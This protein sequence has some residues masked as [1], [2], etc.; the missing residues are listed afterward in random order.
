[1]K[2]TTIRKKKK[3]YPFD[4]S[5]ALIPK[6]TQNFLILLIYYIACDIFQYKIMSTSCLLSPTHNHQKQPPQYP[7]TSPSP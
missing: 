1:M 7:Q 5:R 2:Q 3:K 6:T 4:I